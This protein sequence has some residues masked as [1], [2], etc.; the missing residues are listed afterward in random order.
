MRAIEIIWQS[1]VRGIVKLLELIDIEIINKETKT[2]Y[3]LNVLYIF[4]F[5]ILIKFPINI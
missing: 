2:V 3:V 5:C 4:T 1:D